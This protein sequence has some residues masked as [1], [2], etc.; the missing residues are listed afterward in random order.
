MYN[1]IQETTSHDNTKHN[2]DLTG[3][4]TGCEILQPAMFQ[5]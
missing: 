5:I 1:M 3:Q 4:M 2:P